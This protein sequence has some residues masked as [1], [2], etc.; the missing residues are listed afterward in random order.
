MDKYGQIGP[1]PEGIK[2]YDKIFKFC[3]L[4]NTPL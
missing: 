2:Y 4:P 1:D 3:F